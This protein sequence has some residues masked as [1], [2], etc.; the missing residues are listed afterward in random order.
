MNDES[1]FTEA[2]SRKTNGERDEYLRRAC[3][4][5]AQRDRIAQ[6]LSSHDQSNS[7][8]DRELTGGMDAK[9]LVGTT[10]DAARTLGAKENQV[11][12][13]YRLLHL[14]GEGGMGSVYMAEQL[15]PV[16]RRVAVKIIKQGM[17]SEQFVARF[18]AERQALAL[19]DHPNIAKVLDAG[20]TDRGEPFFVMELVK[21]I[22]ITEF[23]DQ[24]KL[25]TAERLELFIQV[26]NAVQHAHQKGI[27]HRDLKPSNVM[28]AMYDDRPVPKVIDFG[29]AKATHQQLTE[30]TLYTV[31]G[32]IVGTWEYMSPEQAILNQLD[33]DTRTDIYSLGVILYELLTGHTPL[34]LKS[35]G[36]G[37]LE[38]R[39]RRIREE[40][41]SRPSLRVS[42]LGAAAGSLA[43]YRGTESKSL[44]QT[45]RG[46]LDWIVMK[47]LEKDRSK[48]Y[49]TANGFAA[50]I[51]RFLNDEPISFRPPSSWEQCRRLYRKH[52]GIANA[53]MISFATLGIG[54]A[55]ALWQYSIAFRRATELAAKE[56]K[57]RAQNLEIAKEKKTAEE[58]LGFVKDYTMMLA[59]SGSEQD[60]NTALQTAT[61][62]GAS[63]CW[64]LM[65]RAQSKIEDGNPEEAVGILR[66]ALAL[67]DPDD[68][69]AAKGLLGHALLFSGQ[70]DEHLKLHQEL[71]S[72]KLNSVEELIFVGNGL[73]FDT[74]RWL[75]L[76]NRAVQIRESPLALFNRAAARMLSA[77]DRGDLEMAK[78]GIVDLEKVEATGTTPY[79]IAI[80]AQL[81][82]TS[83][84]L[85][86]ERGLSLEPWR[87][88]LEAD[89]E[90]LR[91]QPDFGWGLIVS[92]WYDDHFRP[93]QADES[94]A[95]VMSR[96][97]GGWHDIHAAAMVLRNQSL[98]HWE[99]HFQGEEV[100]E[101]TGLA[102]LLAFD[103]DS[104]AKQRSLDIYSE[105]ISQV[106]IVNV[107]SGF[108]VEIALLAKDAARVKAD[109]MHLLEKNSFATEFDRELVRYLSLQT[110]QA[111]DEFDRKLKHF[112][113]TEQLMGHFTA[114]LLAFA[115][116]DTEEAIEQFRKTRATRVYHTS[117]YYWARAMLERLGATTPTY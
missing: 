46:D 56:V 36:L 37:A 50:E 52:G 68:K 5:D 107:Q 117:D 40:E 24:N 99:S 100:L 57:L 111:A 61:M 69:L 15:Q 1:I 39:L 82:L 65:L 92:A 19:M 91:E 25:G 21:G 79:L 66:R 105:I 18:E 67:T 53:A 38:E 109:A 3:N 14:L 104:N 80:R 20:C 95:T 90:L 48:R 44:T 9:G 13:S 28:V 114:G 54:L 12:G 70:T 75:D 41:P 78:S 7:F 47:A 112:T 22:P 81:H 74:A 34:D 71:S 62:V 42:S 45:L 76:A 86:E 110:N 17:N 6:L 10:I 93:A 30:Q 72:A 97:V 35:L 108:G 89:I 63:D 73:S 84:L 96:G 59:R 29:V 49:E 106:E 115:N 16:K 94:W 88:Q 51:G 31:P 87:Q 77:V 43:T 58:R 101:Q 55:L 102:C 33:V 98:E 85:A 26:C 60:L 4:D 2:L 64:K 23:C 116:D 103:G 27:I 11:L 113:R 32:Q 83:M 8:L